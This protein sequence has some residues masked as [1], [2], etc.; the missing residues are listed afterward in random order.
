[1]RVHRVFDWGGSSLEEG[2]AAE[3]GAR[4]DE[5][6]Q[7]LRHL[8]L[9]GPGKELAD[10]TRSGGRVRSRRPGCVSPPSRE[11]VSSLQFYQA[12]PDS[13]GIGEIV[14]T[15]GTSHLEVWPRR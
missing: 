2:I 12:Q 8:S 14:I 15:G 6:S 13:L 7:I 9:T 4:P 5:A 1:M 10:W 11:L 3:L